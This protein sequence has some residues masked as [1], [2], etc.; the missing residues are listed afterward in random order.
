MTRVLV[1]I[2]TFNEAENIQTVVQSVRAAMPD[3]EVLVIDD[4]SPDGT[5]AIADGLAAADKSVSVLHRKHKNGLGAAYLS[6]FAVGL[7]DGYD[8]LIEFD[9]DGSHPAGVLPKLVAAVTGAAAER[10]IVGLAIGS[11][12]IRG[13]NVV[14]WPRS[15]QLL[16]RG[17]NAYARIML[18]LNVH[19][20]TAGCRAYRAE[21][22]RALHLDSIKTKGYGFQVDMTRRTAAL[23]FAIREVPISF[24]E[25]EFGE[26]K[27][28]GSIIVEA[29]WMVT[30]W[31]LARPFRYV[32][33]ALS[34]R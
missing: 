1:L 6:G 28:S 8:V 16:S 7:A 27:M 25:R 12:W 20:S 33:R 19:D 17:G 4:D 21:T 29:M 34:R 30:L 23:G 22:L 10:D 13:G 31:G 18:G 9:A 14:D 5:G 11:R 26:S 2:P 24:R 32:Q 3:A 15:R